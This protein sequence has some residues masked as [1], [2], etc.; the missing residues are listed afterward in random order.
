MRKPAV[1]SHLRYPL[2]EILGSVA[3]V[4]LLRALLAYGGPLGA[5]QLARETGLTP[6]GAR[7]ALE[8]L[9][10]CGLVGALGQPRSQLF[11]LDMRHPLALALQQLFAQEASRWDALLEALRATLQQDASVEA[12]WYYGSAARGEDHPGSDLDVAIVITGHDVDGALEAVRDALQQLESQFLAHL[13]IVALAPS[14]VARLSGES[15]AWWQNLVRDAKVLKGPRPEQLQA[16]V[17]P[18]VLAT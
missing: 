6:Q 3:Q 9:M 1:Q 5:A 14:D 18:K 15:D 17:Q 12:A 16:R 2:T 7:L 11:A 13:S 10:A 4:R 8:H